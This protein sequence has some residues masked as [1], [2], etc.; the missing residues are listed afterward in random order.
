VNLLPILTGQ[1]KVRACNWAFEGK[2]VARNF[3]EEGEGGMEDEETDG[4]EKDCRGRTGRNNMQQN[5]MAW[6]SCKY[7][8]IS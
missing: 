8:G 5:L 1:I 7:R 3:R 2:D 4:R 6:R